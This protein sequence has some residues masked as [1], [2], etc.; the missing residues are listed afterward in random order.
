MDLTRKFTEHRQLKKRLA[1]EFLTASDELLYAAT[2]ESH[3][4]ALSFR[5]AIELEKL[6]ELAANVSSNYR[7]YEAIVQN[8]P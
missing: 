8:K 4:D 6:R 1:S 5:Y 7:L 3:L 2:E